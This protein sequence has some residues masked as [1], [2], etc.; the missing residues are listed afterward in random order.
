MA[1]KSYTQILAEYRVAIGKHQELIR[2][3]QRVHELLGF[4]KRAKE[5]AYREWVV[6]EAAYNKAHD[7]REQKRL[8]KSRGAKRA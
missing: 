4:M 5:E 1:K 6:A 7:D 8:E 2:Q 3:E